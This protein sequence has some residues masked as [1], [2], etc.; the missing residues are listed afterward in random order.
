MLKQVR[1]LIRTSNPNSSAVPRSN[2]QGIIEHHLPFISEKAP[3]QMHSVDL[4]HA[5]AVTAC[6]AMR[7]AG[8]CGLTAHPARALRR[9]QLPGCSTVFISRAVR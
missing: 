4:M 2:L 7:H 6:S 8:G 3:G 9:A 5:A 1:A